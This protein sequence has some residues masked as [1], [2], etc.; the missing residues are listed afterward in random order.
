M[1][2]RFFR[3]TFWVCVTVVG[4]P[5][6]GLG[7]LGCG[8]VGGALGGYLGG[9]GGAIAGVALGEWLYKWSPF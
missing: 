2:R 9:S 1:E 8:I 3:R 7:A 6:G 4:V 5:S